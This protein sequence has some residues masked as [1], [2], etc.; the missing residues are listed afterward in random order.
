MCKFRASLWLGVMV[1]MVF[2]VKQSVLK[3]FSIYG[4][5][6]L[7]GRGFGAIQCHP[8]PGL[9]TRH[10]SDTIHVP[11]NNQLPYCVR[12]S[13]PSR[14]SVSLTTMLSALNTRTRTRGMRR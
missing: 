6:I 8:G 12:A 13:R 4:F 11:P 1:F 2:M 14:K 3:G 9:A 5:S 10:E 7:G